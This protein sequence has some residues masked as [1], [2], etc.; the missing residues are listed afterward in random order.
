MGDNCKSNNMRAF[1]S[2]SR[3]DTSIVE[4]TKN[5][6][7]VIDF[8][9]IVY[10]DLP[11]P[12]EGQTDRDAISN[13]LE[14][15]NLVFLFLTHNVSDSEHTRAWIEYE[16]AG[17]SFLKKPLIVFQLIGEKPAIPIVYW[18]DVLVW[19]REP[20]RQVVEVQR[21]ARAFA[22]DGYPILR[23]ITGAVIGSVLGPVGAVGGCFHRTC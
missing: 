6:L 2:H 16:V 3:K 5:A 12:T 23:A 14:N 4:L 19:S 13:L 8:S 7:R 21:V 17:A 22:H 1:V 15:C 9:T 20:A 10:E 11:P 18:T